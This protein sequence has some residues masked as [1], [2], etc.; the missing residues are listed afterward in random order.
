TV[1]INGVAATFRQVGV[2][3]GF[4]PNT[5]TVAVTAQDGTTR[6]YYAITV[7][8]ARSTNANLN[9]LDVRVGTASIP[10]SPSFSPS[11][12]SYTAT[13]TPPGTAASVYVSA[14]VQD[15]TATTTINGVGGAVQTV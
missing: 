15:S 4:G 5:I 6:K 1:T 9:T 13:A 8:R 3:L 14:G 11:L 2:G 7:N 10:L 12:T